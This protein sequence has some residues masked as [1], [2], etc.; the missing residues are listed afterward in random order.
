MSSSI[1][2]SDLHGE[3]TPVGR[4]V[5]LVAEAAGPAVLVALLLFAA[6]LV[7]DGLAPARGLSGDI[8]SIVIATQLERARTIGPADLLVIGDSSALMD[9]DPVRLAQSL[10]GITVE[11]L[12]TNA[13]V[14]PAG[15]G[16]MLETYARHV[17]SLPAI[18]LLLHGV[19][20]AMPE[21]QYIE[22]P[23]E[24]FEVDEPL[25]S[26]PLVRAPDIAYERL[27]APAFDL[28]LPGTYGS[29][30]GQRQNLVSALWK[31]HGSL[32]DPNVLRFESEPFEYECSPA[33]TE[34]LGILRHMLDRLQ[35]SRVF[36][37]L[38]PVP[39]ERVGKGTRET[40]AEIEQS[41]VRVLRRAT[42]L[43]LPGSLPDDR[44]A[45][46]THLNAAGRPGYSDLVAEAIRKATA[47]SRSFDSRDPSKQDR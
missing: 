7:L 8:S 20:F 46:Q 21:S 35:P 2:S 37:G 33:F 42:L 14:G 23:V 11:S 38:T 19:S 10:G 39:E 18:L 13:R 16:R 3:G 47:P 29:H 22:H 43:D 44:F 36:L 1:S 31:G 30:Y 9:I 12:A 26:N 34:R 27:I 41:T 28:P 4:A 5:A 25:P 24:W 45:T 40:R 17:G 15:Y 32:E 6:T